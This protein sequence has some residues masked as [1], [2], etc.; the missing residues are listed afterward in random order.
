MTTR[1]VCKY[2]IFFK[3][4][5]SRQL[6]TSRMRNYE[7]NICSPA[8]NGQNFYRTNETNR[9]QATF[10][11]VPNAESTPMINGRSEDK[12]SNPAMTYDQGTQTMD[13]AFNK[14]TA[15]DVIKKLEANGS[16]LE[17][18][19][20]EM[21]EKLNKLQLVVDHWTATNAEDCVPEQVQDPI[22]DTCFDV[23]K[24][25]ASA[26]KVEIDNGRIYNN[27]E[28]IGLE[29][30]SNDVLKRKSV[31]NKGLKK[32]SKRKSITNN[33]DDNSES[34]TSDMVSSNNDKL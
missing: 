11:N 25:A 12:N 8:F 30:Q 18:V 1:L 27:E 33:D 2:K 13:S 28:N 20:G 24:N 21:E 6:E 9:N 34:E 19:I 3:V 17:L 23:L 5:A 26:V 7:N 14:K 31:E 10:S 16:V 4:H 15:E 29:N 22:E 32:L